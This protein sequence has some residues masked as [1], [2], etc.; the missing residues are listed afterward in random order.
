[1]EPGSIALTLPRHPDRYATCLLGAIWQRDRR[2]FC[3]IDLSAASPSRNPVLVHHPK[4]V[5]TYSWYVPIYYT[6]PDGSYTENSTL[7]RP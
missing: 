4:R 6:C 1:M 2:Q 7:G 3:L 5:Q